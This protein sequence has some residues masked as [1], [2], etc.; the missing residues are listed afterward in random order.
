MD[1]FTSSLER[2]GNPWTSHIQRQPP[3]KDE[4]AVSVSRKE[5]VARM[6]A[7]IGPKH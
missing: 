2:L 4:T 7:F 5:A 1:L 6:D 3:F